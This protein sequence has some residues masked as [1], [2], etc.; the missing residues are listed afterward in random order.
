M[1]SGPSF[2]LSKVGWWAGL[3][4]QFSV[5]DRKSDGDDADAD[6]DEADEVDAAVADAGMEDDA[7]D[8]GG[9]DGAE[10]A[11]GAERP[12]CDTQLIVAFRVPRPNVAGQDA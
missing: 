1:E 6:H 11:E 9:G 7:G 12:G 4:C 8:G 2:F 3:G 10:V 5:E